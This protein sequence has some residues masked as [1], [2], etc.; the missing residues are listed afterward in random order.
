[1][2]STPW[3]V[4]P[5]C[6]SRPIT[7]SPSAA[8]WHTVRRRPDT[9]HGPV[10]V[11]AGPGLPGA[12]TEARAVADLYATEAFVEAGARTATTRNAMDGARLAHLAA[13]GRVR[14][15]NPLFSCL[16]LTD[17]PLMA[18]D[19]E[20]LKQAPRTVVLASCDTGRPVVRAGDELLGLTATLLAHGTTQLV[21][22]VLPVHDIDTTEFMIDF[23]RR[24]IAGEAPAHALANVQASLAQEQSRRAATAGFVCI[25]DGFATGAW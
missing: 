4:L 20:Q 23:H 3:S 7:V 11:A 5:S 9:A 14:S 8:L 12:L 13:H 22:S 17:G 18:Y 16:D 25:G 6:A 2:Q 24:L 19:L 1:L 15:D 21:A 10:L